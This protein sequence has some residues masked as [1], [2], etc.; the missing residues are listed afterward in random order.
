MDKAVA[1]KAS[2]D[3]EKVTWA[4]MMA[5]EKDEKTPE[6]PKRGSKQEDAD[7]GDEMLALSDDEG[8][9]LDATPPTDLSA[10]DLKR[11]REAE[12]DFGSP[13]KTR[14][15]MPPAPP[16][17]PLPPAE[18]MPLDLDDSGLTPM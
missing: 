12:G 5:Q 6:S 7:F 15:E 4:D 8:A 9:T 13:K 3:K 18:D 2:R 14:T 1:K 11:K 10:T 16:P 17:P